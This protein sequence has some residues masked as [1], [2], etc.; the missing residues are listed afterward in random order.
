MAKSRKTVRLF[1]ALVLLILFAQQASA[2]LNLW[3]IYVAVETIAAALGVLMIAYAGVMW[4]MAGGPQDRDDAKKTLIY[5]M[6][7]LLVVALAMDI[8][9]AVYCTTMSST[10]YGAGIC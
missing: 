5:V 2:K 4:I 1:T 10:S 6:V 8:V 9:G 7:G 3:E